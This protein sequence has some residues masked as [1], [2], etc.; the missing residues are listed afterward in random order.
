MIDAPDALNVKGVR[1]G[2]GGADV[3][4]DV[5]LTVRKGT[6]HTL[7]GV[8]GAGKTTLLRLISG[9]EPTRGGTVEM[10]GADMTDASPA[11]RVRRGLG[12][13]PEGRRVFPNLSV[14][15]NIR[16]GAVSSRIPRREFVEERDRLLSH[17]P[18]LAKRERQFAGSLSGGE[19]QMLAIAMALISKPSV[20]M[21]DEPSLGLAP[22]IVDQ[23]FAEIESLRL[24]GTTILLVEQF[25]L[26]ALALADDATVLRLGRVVASGPAAAIREDDNLHAAYLGS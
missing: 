14:R 11:Q 25:A 2:Y 13:V 6:I 4:H 16:L 1:A 24:S 26:R 15:D 8:N 19:Q 21:L 9:V 10:H 3:L 17:F 12:H 5:S 20:L 22:I 7:V 18:V 23:V